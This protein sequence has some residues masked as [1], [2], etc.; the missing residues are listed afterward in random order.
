MTFYYV[1][2]KITFRIILDL[3]VVF[4]PPAYLLFEITSLFLIDQHQV[5]IVA[6]RELLVDVSHGGSQII[7]S[8]E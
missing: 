4:F 8:Q 5:Q 2:E 7:A 3:Y 1:N 6:H